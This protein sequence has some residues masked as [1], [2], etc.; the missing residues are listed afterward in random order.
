MAPEISSLSGLLASSPRMGFSRG[1]IFR[2]QS[3][4]AVPSSTVNTIIAVTVILGVIFIAFALFVIYHA[5]MRKVDREQRAE[6]A[7]VQKRRA[8][9]TST[10]PASESRKERGERREPETHGER[11]GAYGDNSFPQNATSD[12]LTSEFL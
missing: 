11:R 5:Y 1:L 8:L 2:R 10:S 3:E 12:L 9:D 4:K 6:R 7:R